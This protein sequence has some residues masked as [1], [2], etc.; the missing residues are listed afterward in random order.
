MTILRSHNDTIVLM[1][2]IEPTDFEEM[3]L[4]HK[5]SFDDLSDIMEFDDE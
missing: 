3:S 2:D 1:Q 4:H 5:K